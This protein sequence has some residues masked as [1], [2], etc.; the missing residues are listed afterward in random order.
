MIRIRAILIATLCLA[1]S[2]SAQAVLQ[3]GFEPGFDSSSWTHSENGGGPLNLDLSIAHSGLSSLRI[4]DSVGNYIIARDLAASMRDHYVEVWFYDDLSSDLESHLA[5]SEQS[6]YLSS[7]T[8]YVLLGVESYYEPNHYIAVEGWHSINGWVQGP[9]RS[10]GWHKA[11]IENVNGENHCYI[12]DQLVRVSTFQ[13][14]WRYL[15]LMENNKTF[16]GV[17]RFDDLLVAPRVV[18]SSEASSWSQLKSL[19]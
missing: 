7:T 9:S 11:T 12:D 15:M 3:E 1:A 13:P 18:V 5:V 17:S 14:D 6:N 8:G 16:G 4:D 2:I 19:Y 10:L